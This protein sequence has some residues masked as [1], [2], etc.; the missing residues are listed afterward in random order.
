MSIN[1]LTKEQIIDKLQE[2]EYNNDEMYETLMNIA[3]TLE[4]NTLNTLGDEEFV[5]AVLGGFNNFYNNLPD[6]YKKKD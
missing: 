2:V 3:L 6:D 4:I 5:Y 1:E